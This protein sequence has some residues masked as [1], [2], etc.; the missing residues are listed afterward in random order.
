TG[1]LNIEGCRIATADDVRCTGDGFKSDKYG[2]QIGRGEA[3]MQGEA[4]ELPTAGRWPANLCHDGSN[5][6]L[7][8]FPAE[9]GAFAPVRGTEPSTPAKNVYGTFARG[10]GAFHGDTGSAARFFYC[11]KADR[12]DREHGLA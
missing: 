4:W 11:A 12:E 3:T 10:G 7:A 1:A 6:V 8:H 2:G 9:A 5:E